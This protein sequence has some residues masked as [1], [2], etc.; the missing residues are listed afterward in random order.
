MRFARST[1]RHTDCERHD[2]QLDCTLLST[3]AT[4]K[5]TANTPRRTLEQRFASCS[6]CDMRD[7]PTEKRTETR[8]SPQPIDI[9]S[10]QLQS[11]RSQGI[12]IALSLKKRTDGREERGTPATY[13][14][15]RIAAGSWTHYDDVHDL[16]DSLDTAPGLDERVQDLHR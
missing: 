16:Q 9:P 4:C 12:R 11:A 3:A 13:E 7:S 6:L 10:V 1:R 2:H 14:R 5:G 8:T 15:Q